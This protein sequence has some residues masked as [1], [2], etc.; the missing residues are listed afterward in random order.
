MFLLVLFLKMVGNGLVML[1]LR[2][3]ESL[4]PRPHMLF[5]HPRT[6]MGG[7]TPHAISP[8]P[9]I[10]LWDENQTNP[11]DVL[12]SMVPKLT[13]FRPYLD[14][15]RSGQRNKDSDLSINSFFANNFR[16]KQDS[17]IIQAPSCFSFQEA[18]KHILFFYLE[19]P[20]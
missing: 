2:V 11:W 18:S 3:I 12:S 5:P 20:S 19:R 13:S 7:A 9:E 4:N 14:L 1:R 6:H 16:T 8:L 15:S 10:E 17:G